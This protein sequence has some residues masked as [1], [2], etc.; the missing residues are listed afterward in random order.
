MKV[1]IQK[2]GIY[3]ADYNFRT[4][5]VGDRE[6]DPFL[7]KFGDSPNCDTYLI[8]QFKNHRKV[9]YQECPVSGM[10]DRRWEFSEIDYGTVEFYVAI[11]DANDGSCAFM[12]DDSHI[13]LYIDDDFFKIPVVGNICA[14]SDNTIYH[15]RIDFEC[16]TGSY[17]GLDQ[18]H[19]KVYINDTG[20]GPYWFG[21]VEA[22]PYKVKPTDM[23]LRSDYDSGICKTY[24][25]AFGCT[26]L[27]TY[28]IGDNKS[29]ETVT[30]LSSEI[31][32]CNVI[33][34][35]GKVH[36]AII[37]TSEDLSVGD[38]IK[39][40]DDND[41]LCFHG[42][43]HSKKRDG[44]KFKW[45]AI[46]YNREL[47]N[48]FSIDFTDGGGSGSGGAYLVDEMYED[49]IDQEGNF[50]SYSSSIDP[51]GNCSEEFSNLK[52]SNKQIK[53]GFNFLDDLEDGIWV[54]EPDGVVWFWKIADI[55]E[56][57]IYYWATENF[58]E[59]TIGTTGTSIDFVD[60][61][62]GNIEIKNDSGGKCGHKKVIE[63]DDDDANAHYFVHNLSTTYEDITIEFWI[64]SSDVTYET[65]ISLLDSSDSV[66][67]RIMIDDDKWQAYH[68]ATWNDL[69]YTPS[70]NQWYRIRID[71]NT[72]NTFDVW[73]DGY[74]VVDSKAVEDNDAAAKIKISSQ[75]ADSSYKIYFDAYGCSEEDSTYTTGGIEKGIC[76]EYKGSIVSIPKTEEIIDQINRVILYGAFIEGERI[77]ATVNDSDSQD[78]LDIIPY[79]DHFPH[80][81]DATELADIAQKILDR[82]GM[83]DYPKYIEIAI[84]GLD[85]TSF[86]KTIKLN[87]SPYKELTIT[88]N[89]YILKDKFDVKRN[90]H[91]YTLSSGLVMEHRV[92]NQSEGI[93]IQTADEE[94]LDIV[95]SNK[96]TIYIKNAD[97]TVNDDVDGGY[98]R[99]DIWI[100]TS[101]D[102]TFI[103]RNPAD[104][105]ADWKE[106]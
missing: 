68:T 71:Y 57:D 86:G 56:V 95:A 75:A 92:L 16:T 1:E 98:K 61:S 79:I 59:E 106:I 10:T 62:S 102:G 64:K 89:Y 12:M 8:S 85:Y 23:Q 93:K 67:C 36:T 3:D 94:Q 19:Y 31:E 33:R 29:L 81:Y 26:W 74:H 54:D 39:I 63:I 18:W 65:L 48:K 69:G 24:W 43:I 5:Q 42:P 72:D 21:G 88:R 7:D 83:M 66:I 40:Y 82:T 47:N 105:A 17:Q 91:Y 46:S 101:D 97:P 2:S 52:F 15:I 99:G 9:I 13:E 60:S 51:D 35:K 76:F 38:I 11:N 4:L 73:I 6:P 55:P 78:L 103:C 87:F 45:E 34:E 32:V 37:K 27:G 14:A 20:Y 25:D 44:S 22:A 41:I 28:E 77:T 50:L 70:D 80:V 96:P 30:S 100:N 90:I 84:S 104:G 58:K 53:E 49:I